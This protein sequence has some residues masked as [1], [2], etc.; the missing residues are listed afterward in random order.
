[1]MMT[2]ILTCA[3]AVA[4]AAEAQ[5]ARRVYVVGLLS[6][7]ATAVAAAPYVDALKETS[8]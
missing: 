6:P 8:P 5:P 7:A 1:M 3:L 2:A 4:T